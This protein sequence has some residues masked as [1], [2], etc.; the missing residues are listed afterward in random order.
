MKSVT[1]LALLLVLQSGIPAQAQT[2]IES[3][4]AYIGKEDL[5]NSNGQRLTQPWQILRQDRANYHRFG[6]SHPGDEWDGFFGDAGNRAIMERMLQN[7][8]ID[9]SA[10]RALVAGGTTVRV[11]IYGRNGR[12]EALQIYVDH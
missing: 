4:R 10:A 3:Y 1:L 12:G 9:P 5:F 11:D 8:R 2:L 7:G 6:I